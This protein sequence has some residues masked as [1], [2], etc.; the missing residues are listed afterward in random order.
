MRFDLGS[1]D[2]LH[3]PEFQ[4]KR[5]R[6]SFNG[7]NSGQGLPDTNSSL[8]T[9]HSADYFTI[10]CLSELAFLESSRPGY[11][12]RVVDFT[13]GRIG[14]GCIRFIG[15]TDIRGLDLD[16][17]V[18]FRKHEVVVYEDES[19]KPAVGMGLNK[20]AEVT[21]SLKLGLLNQNNET[22]RKIIENLQLKTKRQ[23]AHFISYDR[24]TGEWKFLVQH[25][26][27]FGLIDDD[28]ED[29]TMD[30]VSTEVQLPLHVNGVEVSDI[31][32]V[33]TSLT[34]T[35][36][37]SH[38]LPAHLGLDPIKMNEMRML[39][40]PSLGEEADLGNDDSRLPLNRRPLFSRESSRFQKSNPHLIRKTPLALIEYST[41]SFGSCSPGSRL[42][43]QKNNSV[44]FKSTN[45]EGF[46]LEAK[47]QTPVTS[48]HSCNVVDSALFMGRSFRVGWGPNGILVHSGA[49]IGSNE[50]IISSVIN[51]EKVSF[52]KV[53]RDE[54]N[55]IRH[56]LVD[57]FF[58]SPL[59]LHKE[60]NHETQE[61]EVGNCSLKL[62]KLI[63]DSFILPDICRSYI[64]TVED[65]LEIPG[66]SLSSRMVLVHQVMVW[67]LIK[68]L[69]SSRKV[70][71]K[72]KSQEDNDSE[73]EMIY[74][75]RES[76][77]DVDT[78]ALPL[79]RRAEFSYWLQES[80]CHRVQ[81]EVSSLD[82][83]G[84]LQ[85][86]FLLLTG[87]Q[88]D[89]AT[90]LAASRGDVRLACL[91]SQAGGFTES[92]LDIN[93]QIEIWRINGLDFSFVE[94]E[95]VRIFQLL[96]GD[97][98]LALQDVNIDWKRFL[99]LLMWYNL[100]PDTSLPLVFRSY[101]QLLNEGKAPSP[102]PIYIDEGSVEEES[103]NSYKEEKYDL[104]YYLMLLHA[105]QETDYGVLKA[106]FSAFASTNDPLDYHMIWH[107]RAVLEA[108][109]VVNSNDLH[110]LDMGLI[111]QLLCLGQCHWAIYV[112]LHMPYR[113]DFPYLHANVIRE[114]LFQYCEAWSSKDSQRELIEDL[115]IPSP[116]IHEALAMY[117]SYL[118][119]CSKA[120]EHFL[121][122]GGYWQKSHTI[123]MTSVAH[124]L[125]LSGD[126][127][128]IF[129]IA[130]SMES[131]KEEIEDWDLGAGIYLSFYLLRS[132]LKEDNDTMNEVDSLENKNS[133]CADFISHLNE[134]LVV[135]SN[136]LPLDARVVY[137]MMGEEICNLLLS[138]TCEGSTREVQM[139]CFDTVFKAPISEDLR[140]CHL[141]EAVSCFTSYLSDLVS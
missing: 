71:G 100:S 56:E 25:F 32:D 141:Q 64:E 137:S 41:S 19:L 40:F 112:A 43:L 38:S 27:R 1:T 42:M 113:D 72:L 107:Q 35:T 2:L 98:H 67:E 101:Q 115:G 120:L 126:H 99:G 14:Y 111:S 95:R 102:V 23:G 103:L 44:H 15:E 11:C 91:L 49:P 58:A 50:S 110:V 132:S 77:P 127:L 17:I 3:L 123:F 118:G 21:L 135:W 68:V 57:S 60:I 87:R 52:D 10:P 4:C 88:L 69:F 62:Q 125:Y 9:L 89:A 94:M 105:N 65:Q 20:P 45:A 22:L 90:D 80:V 104:S 6:V 75:G 24:K 81:E 30:D 47:Q 18:K 82:E 92:R 129:R 59:N 140:K 131:H 8:P 106:M 136:K 66:L 37:L 133:A 76:T 61:V 46:K 34:D 108:V 31:D 84:Q 79:I 48:S 130:T 124:S 97:I 28:E 85:H 121:K 83:S 55:R 70:S 128:E 39:M 78:E 53:A 7:E 5:R 139:W 74:E 93:Q 26:S 96:A 122:C 116:W 36:L 12:S 119:D 33:E 117:Y 109:G 86:I 134:S 73:K 54:N 16:D 51:L 63:C 114:I 13:V 29:I 138:H